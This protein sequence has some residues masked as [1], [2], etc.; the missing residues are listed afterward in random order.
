MF[1][2][3][4]SKNLPSTEKIE[5]LQR[6]TLVRAGIG[7]G[8]ACFLGLSGVLGML[9]GCVQQDTPMCDL[10]SAGAWLAV[11]DSLTHGK[12]AEHNSYPR[13]LSKMFN[14]PVLSYGANGE[15]SDKLLKR[16]PALLAQYR[17]ALV[18]VTTGGNDFLQ[19][20]DRAQTLENLK[21]IA[22]SIRESGALPVFFA[23]PTPSLAALVSGLKDDP[24]F[25]ELAKEGVVVIKN[26]VSE[27][28]SNSK[29]RSDAIHPNEAGY[30][31]MAEAAHALLRQCRAT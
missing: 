13:Q 18:L 10:P 19:K 3:A 25:E 7:F 21:A 16:L 9:S 5:Q 14:R 29:L 20:T 31:K 12:G 8:A 11:G 24:V 30:Q 22:K 23:I 27:V 26:T 28:L 15:R 4:P 17:P 1:F 2:S 6:R